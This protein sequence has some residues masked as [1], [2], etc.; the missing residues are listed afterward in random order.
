MTRYTDVF[1]DEADTFELTAAGQV[2]VLLPLV[3]EEYGNLE[4]DAEADKIPAVF[5]NFEIPDLF[6][7]C[8]DDRWIWGGDATNLFLLIP[9]HSRLAQELMLRGLV[10]DTPAEKWREQFNR[11]WRA[12]LVEEEANYA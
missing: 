10:Y 3:K 4:Y 8:G 5:E 6:D 11:E 7:E 9:E 1:F 2:I 12:A